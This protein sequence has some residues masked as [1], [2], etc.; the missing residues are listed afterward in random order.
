MTILGDAGFVSS[1]VRSLETWYQR[2]D[3]SP[4]F[5]KDVLGTVEAYFVLLGPDAAY[6]RLWGLEG[7]PVYKA[8]F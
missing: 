2:V 7:S 8:S 3:E 1:T 6:W 4:L 5:E